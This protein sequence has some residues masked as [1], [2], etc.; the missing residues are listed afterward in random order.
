MGESFDKVI[1]HRSL[2]FFERKILLFQLGG[3]GGRAAG[4]QGCRYTEANKGVRCRT[5]ISEPVH[6]LP[7]RYWRVVCLRVY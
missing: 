3:H 5:G 2:I 1:F 4:Q 7:G 6:H